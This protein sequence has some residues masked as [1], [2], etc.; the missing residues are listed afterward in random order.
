MVVPV[1]D[2]FLLSLFV[3][4][5]LKGMSSISVIQPL[6]VMALCALLSLACM[7]AFIRWLVANKMGKSIRDAASAPIMSQMHQAKAGTPTMGGLIVWAVVTVVALVLALGCSIAPESSACTISF[8]SRAQTWLP[9]GSL[10]GAGLVGLI[11]D[12]WN[13]RRWGP[14]G[15]GLRE[16]HRL[17]LYLGIAA[18]GAWWFYTK[19]DWQVLHVPFIGTFDIGWWYIPFF[20]LTVVATS[21]S[22]NLTDGL[23][24]LVGGPLLAS[25]GAY[26]IIA[27]SQGRTDLASLCAAVMG[28]MV[29]F[30]WFNI[31]PAKVFMGDTGAMGLGTLLA[32]VA[33]MT[34]QPLLLVIIGLPFVFESASVIVQVTSK[35]LRQGKKV[36][37]SS[38]VHHHFQA[39]GWPEP[40]IVMRAWLLSFLCAGI[41]GVLALVDRL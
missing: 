10:V 25:F 21:H 30:L 18:I 24:G 1:G 34:N 6:I 32:V 13:I 31:H 36:F 27:W 23:D 4:A 22:V 3:H 19:L 11:D 17:L 15:G 37:L 29:G 16:R 40:Q 9:L 38:P 2:W 26:A 39:L 41:G 8:L 7:P 35:K 28:A 14:K 20:L 12:Y 33:L 5:S